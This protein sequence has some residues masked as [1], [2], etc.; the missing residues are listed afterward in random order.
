MGS[1]RQDTLLK[2][3]KM[4]G[5]LFVFTCS[6]FLYLQG[7][8]GDS[9]IYWRPGI[10]LSWSDF[11]ALSIPDSI[12]TVEGK[13]P[14]AATACDVIINEYKSPDGRECFQLMAVFLRYSSWKAK[15]FDR[16][17]DYDLLLHEQ[18]HFD[19]IEL[20]IRKIKLKVYGEQD[21]LT[22]AR[23]LEIY[24]EILEEDIKRSELY[25]L[26]TCNGKNL[27]AQRRWQAEIADELTRLSGYSNVE[28]CFWDD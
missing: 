16:I 24:Q 6:T 10:K 17:W 28:I 25:D 3:S 27:E 2:C 12:V 26:E 9:V 1:Q 14:S 22:N 18:L 23:F 8:P 21:E 11:R 5:L 13:K 7:Q 20:A 15:E 19:L 4:K